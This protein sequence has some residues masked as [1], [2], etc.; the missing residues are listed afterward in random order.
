MLHY[1]IIFV[2]FMSPFYVLCCW[3]QI[4]S[5]ALRGAGDSTGPMVIMLS[6]FVVFRQVY[7]FIASRLFDSIYV[8]ALAYP[9]GWLLCSLLVYIRY[10]RGKWEKNYSLL[11]D[12]EK[13]QQTDEPQNA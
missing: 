2:R 4:F 12:T 8:T 6:S 3:N 1:G 5:G 10:R 9:I 7:L 11:V 13:A